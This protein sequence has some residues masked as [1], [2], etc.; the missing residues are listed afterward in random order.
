MRKS[1]IPL[2]VLIFMAFISSAAAPCIHAQAKVAQLKATSSQVPFGVQLGADGT[3][4]LPFPAHFSL[5]YKEGF[6]VLTVNSPWPGAARG[7][8]YVL[9]P[10]GSAK[11]TG[12]KADR[13]IQTP[14]SSV[15]SFST[16]YLPALEAIGELKSLVG[17]DNKDY[18]YNPAVRKLIAEGKVVETTKSF[19]PDIERLISLNPDVILTYGVGSEWDTHPKMEEAGLPVVLLADWNEN[20]PLARA[21]WS[22]FLA[23]FFNK[24]GEALAGFNAIQSEYNSIRDKARKAKDKP[25]VL[26]GGPYNGTWS[27]S[28]GGSYMARLIADA[29]GDYLWASNSSTGSLTL[30]IEAVFGK[31]MGAAIWLN[32]D[33]S[34]TKLTEVVAMDPRFA[35]IPAFAE[36][37]VWNSTLRLSPGGGNDY[38]ESAAMQ[39]QVV[40][41]DM[42]AIF[43]PELMPDH[44]F[45]YYRKLGK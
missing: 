2:T 23:S 30:S 21:E 16:T 41:A 3:M 26:V 5:Q 39:P 34:A 45:F 29:G 31:A 20:E 32:P 36:G 35:S 10:R 15:V 7:Y 11:P 19:S 33:G 28:G 42:V 14:V 40:L 24:E 6:K 1:S 22:V 27:V 17:V 43:H 44:R 9:Y 25:S 18:I 8:S 4:K 37:N 13:F 12:I 38:Y